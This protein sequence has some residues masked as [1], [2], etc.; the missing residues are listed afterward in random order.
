MGADQKKKK[1]TKWAIYIIH[2][3]S[4]RRQTNLRRKCCSVLQKH[5]ERNWDKYILNLKLDEE[6]G[7]N[8]LRFRIKSQSHSIG[9]RIGVIVQSFETIIYVII[10]FSNSLVITKGN[11]SIFFLVIMLLVCNIHQFC[12]W[13]ISVGKPNWPPLVGFF[14]SNHIFSIYKAKT[15]DL[16]TTQTHHLLVQ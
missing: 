3:S 16:G 13:L 4:S 14:L 9:N 1:S 7:S 12:R 15:W 8:T 11:N 5:T 2:S 6:K 10:D